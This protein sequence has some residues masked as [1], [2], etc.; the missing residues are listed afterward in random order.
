MQVIDDLGKIF[1]CLVLTGNIGK[2]DAVRGRNIDL[3][4]ALSHTE[5]HCIGAA[6]LGHHFLCHI[7]SEGSKDQ[8]RQNK[9]QEKAEQWR[10]AFF[11]IS[12]EFRTRC[13]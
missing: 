7:L 1:F 9:R 13:I 8:D 4:I 10:H 3:G 5:R 12:C 6:R 2:T 11:N